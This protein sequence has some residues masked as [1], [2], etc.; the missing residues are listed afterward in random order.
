MS[1]WL[2]A[3]SALVAVSDNAADALHA[4]RDLEAGDANGVA[5]DLYRRYF[6]W[7]EKIFQ[8]ENEDVQR[9]RKLLQ[10]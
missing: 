3:P 7:L 8:P 4:G 5:C 10:I 1:D 6:R 9:I 2:A